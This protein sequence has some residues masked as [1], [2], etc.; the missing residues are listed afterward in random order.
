MGSAQ[1]WQW[2]RLPTGSHFSGTLGDF[3]DNPDPNIKRWKWQRTFKTVM[4]LT[5][6]RSTLFTFIWTLLI[7]F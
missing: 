5:V 3:Y 1:A 7:A 2:K 6:S 4:E